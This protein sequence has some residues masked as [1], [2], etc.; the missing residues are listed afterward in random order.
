MVVSELVKVE[1]MG[2]VFILERFACW[3]LGWLADVTQAYALLI[4]L[5]GKGKEKQGARNKE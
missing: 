1:E 5:F 3:K 4:C 2:L